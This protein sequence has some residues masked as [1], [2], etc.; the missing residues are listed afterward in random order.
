M[1]GEREADARW[2]CRPRWR[3]VC[4]RASER[5][6][7]VSGLRCKESVFVRCLSRSRENSLERRVRARA[8]RS[9][10]AAAES[11]P[12]ASRPTKPYSAILVC[13]LPAFGINSTPSPHRPSTPPPVLPDRRQTRSLILRHERQDHPVQGIEEEDQA[14]RAYQYL[15]TKRGERGGQRTRSRA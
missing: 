6:W 4:W 10:A 7:W 5:S 2:K 9:R 3:R 15:Y 13:A 11:A 8:G 1:C 12:L 14:A